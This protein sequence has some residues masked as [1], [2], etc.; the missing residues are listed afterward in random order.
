MSNGIRGLSESSASGNLPSYLSQSAYSRSFRADG[1]LNAE[2]DGTAMLEIIYD[3]APGVTLYFANCSSEPEC[4]QAINWLATEAGGPN[5]RRRTQ[6]GV[7]IIVNDLTFFNV[8]PYDGT[9]PYSQALHSAVDQGVAVFKSVGNS[10]QAHY[11]GLFTDT[12]GDTLHEFDVSLG[13]PRVNNA[14]ETL[15][16]TINPGGRIII[17]L[18]WHDPFSA[19]TNNYDLCVYN[20]PDSPS[21]NLQQ[22]LQCITT[23]ESPGTPTRRL[24]YPPPGS[25]PVATIVTLGVGIIVRPG[26]AGQLG[27]EDA[28][29]S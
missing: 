1:N 23:P 11:Q 12:D 17:D 3:V 21:P 27:L 26:N 15:N 19:S 8:G 5:A 13:Q 20:S 18:Q 7:D 28:M 10:A 16:V 29:P 4:I 24:I 14:G 25:P 6:G 2:A 22:A 9:S